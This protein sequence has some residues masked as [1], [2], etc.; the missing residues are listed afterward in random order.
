MTNNFVTDRIHWD[1]WLRASNT[2]GKPLTAH[3]VKHV[4]VLNSFLT[5]LA[6]PFKLVSTAPDANSITLGSNETVLKY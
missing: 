4:C 3:Q 1:L 5:G 2:Y 6:W